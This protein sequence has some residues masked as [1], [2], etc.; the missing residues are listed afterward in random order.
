[1]NASDDAKG[2]FCPGNVK[3]ILEKENYNHEGKTVLRI[4][5]AP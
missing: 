3:I 5:L 1:M 2:L 4:L